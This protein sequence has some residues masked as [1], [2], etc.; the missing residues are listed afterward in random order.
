MHEISIAQ[1]I[2]ELVDEH[3]RR[4]TFTRAHVV[5]VAI[6]VLSHVEPRALELGFDVVARGTAAEGAKLVIDR[7]PG[8]AHCAHCARDVNIGGYGEGCP[9][10]GGAELTVVG[11]DEMRVV[12]LEVE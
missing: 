6:G 8:T 11:G 5:R 10:C 12:D 2:V 1:S 3:A 7:P 9:V 4:D